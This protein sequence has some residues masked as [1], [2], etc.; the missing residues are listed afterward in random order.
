MH[1]TVAKAAQTPNQRANSQ[2]VRSAVCKT[3]VRKANREAVDVL[4]GKSMIL[5]CIFTPLKALVS[6]AVHRAAVESCKRNAVSAGNTG[7]AGKES[8]R[9]PWSAAFPRPRD[10][11]D[12]SRTF[13]RAK[14]PNDR[15][16]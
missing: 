2:S 7:N 11:A 14:L 13:G 12:G 16:I 4:G 6:S 1:S 10:E 8:G 3:A 5:V 9:N 15:T